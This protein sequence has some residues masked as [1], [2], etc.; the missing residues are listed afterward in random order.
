MTPDPA[1]EA[2]PDYRFSLANERTVLAW[3]R[4]SLALLAASV[5]VS[6]LVPDFAVPGA[7]EAV[8]VLMG[9]LSLA[10]S[11]GGVLRWRAVQR[12]MRR[13]EPLPPS[14]SVPLQAAGLGVVAVAVAV[15][16]LTR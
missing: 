12:A 7:R 16:A 3:F 9:L 8:G 6:Q 2:E 5:G 11:I 14:R 4:T 1:P 13:G 15:L 10:S